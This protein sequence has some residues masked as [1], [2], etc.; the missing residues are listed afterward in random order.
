[1]IDV[2]VDTYPRLDYRSVRRLKLV[3][4]AAAAVS[5]SHTD[6]SFEPTFAHYDCFRFAVSLTRLNSQP[7]STKV[8]ERPADQTEPLTMMERISSNSEIVSSTEHTEPSDKSEEADKVPAADEKSAASSDLLK[9]NTGLLPFPDNLMSLL[10]S[11]VVSDIIRWLP[12][13]DAFCLKPA[14]FAERV[15]DKYF[16]GTKFESFTRKLNRWYV[17]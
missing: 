1:M 10:D 11:G 16:Q 13:G 6:V 8:M 15:L 2:P 14:L 4:L 5:F 12:E 3:V 7:L 9:M 17:H